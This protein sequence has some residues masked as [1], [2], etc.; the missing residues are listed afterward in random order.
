MG[1]ESNGVELSWLDTERS[2]FGGLDW[3]GVIVYLDLV[4]IFMLS[5]C[6]KHAKSVS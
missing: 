2:H 3:T 5:L 6:P 4:G 1:R